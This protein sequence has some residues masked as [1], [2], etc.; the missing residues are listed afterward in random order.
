MRRSMGILL[1][2]LLLLGCSACSFTTDGKTTEKKTTTV[3]EK[4]D[5]TEDKVKTEAKDAGDKVKTETE[6]VMPDPADGQ[7]TDTDGI[8]EKDEA[9]ETTAMPD[10]GSPSQGVT[11][12]ERPARH[13][14][15]TR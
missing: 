2:A 10:T 12:A 1:A 11:P 4:A 7:V 3:T 5:E 6:Q 13:G 15:K 9:P 8:L 14:A